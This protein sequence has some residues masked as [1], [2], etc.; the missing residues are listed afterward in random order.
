MTTA[1]GCLR[2]LTATLMRLAREGNVE[3][4]RGYM[5]SDAFLE[6]FNGLD[7]DRRQS[8]ML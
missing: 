6:A 3:G 7:P 8:A 5:S 1:V 4:F 2:L